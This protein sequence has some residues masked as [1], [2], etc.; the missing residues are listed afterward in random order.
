MLLL[1]KKCGVRFHRMWTDEHVFEKREVML[2]KPGVSYV[3]VKPEHI[4]QI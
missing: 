4:V 1:M 3:A 2:R